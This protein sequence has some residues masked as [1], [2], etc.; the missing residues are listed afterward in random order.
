MEIKRNHYL[1]QLK[2]KAGN[3]KIKVITGLRRSGKS[4]LLNNIYR[5]Y[6]VAN[7]VAPESIISFS[8]N[9][10]KD[11]KYRNPIKL[12]EE[13][14]KRAAQILGK[15]YLF[16]DE[17]GL[18]LP[19]PNP[20]LEGGEITF[21]DVLSDYCDEP[22]FDVYVTGSNSYML[23]KDIATVFRDRGDII[24][25]APLTFRE[26]HEYK[27]KDVLSDWNEFFTYGGMPYA[28]AW[29]NTDEEKRKYLAGLFEE[30]YLKDIKEHV[31]AERDD[32]L[33]ELILDLCSS[34]GS[35]TNPTKI[36]N[37]M[38]SVK[39]VRVTDV[40]IASYLRGAVDSFLFS[41]A[42]RYDVKGK[43]YFK[44][45]SKYYCADVGLR[46][47][48]LNL[49]QQEETHIMENIIFNELCARGFKPDVGVV[50]F[51]PKDET[52]KTIRID[53]E[54]D[55]IVNAP[56]GRIYIQ[57]ALDVSD[58]EK[59]DREVRPFRG[60]SDFRRKIVIDR[61]TPKPYVDET[62][63]LFCSVFDFLLDPSLMG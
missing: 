51:F 18:C 19:V 9:K 39:G 47:C 61:S 58:P 6:L 59:R 22:D 55:F 54:I 41:E 43:R 50:E 33:R 29:C 52:G 45:P 26:F 17:I 63:V 35:L 32:V 25:M 46:N 13:I 38:K 31:S 57:S 28:V 23:S 36:A 40:T 49:R 1:E 53:T 62:G 16:I 11:A 7:G 20:D 60:L 56:L 12:G 10:K 15:K 14:E 4:Y 44:Y 8:L 34:I 21:N 5:D 42:L 30:T 37:T 3:G 48:W 2:R 24:E 27:N